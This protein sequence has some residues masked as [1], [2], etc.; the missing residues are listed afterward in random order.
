MANPYP[1]SPIVPDGPNQ[2][3]PPLNPFK[4]RSAIAGF[5]TAAGIIGPIINGGLGAIFTYFAENVDM[6]QA[7]TD[8]AINGF[9][10]FIA[11]AGFIWYGF[12]R[13]A[14]NFRLTFAKR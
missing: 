3:L 7:Q 12:E 9:N 13:A 6:I 8:A 10:A 11:L 1:Q 14:P 5:L 4:A 2:L